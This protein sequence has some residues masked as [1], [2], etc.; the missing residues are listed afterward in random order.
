MELNGKDIIAHV[1]CGVKNQILPS[2]AGFRMTMAGIG[3]G[4]SIL[5]L[6]TSVLPALPVKRKQIDKNP[7][8]SLPYQVRDRLFKKG[9]DTL[10]AV[11]CKLITLSPSTALVIKSVY[12]NN[13][14]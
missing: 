10:T 7:L 3:E 5:P 8:T 13:Y 14:V 11:I 2:T 9:G 6:Q 1:F 12:S 4:T